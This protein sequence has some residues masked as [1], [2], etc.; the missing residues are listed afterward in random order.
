ML[1]ETKE[2]ALFTLINDY[3][4]VLGAV[5]LSPKT[6]FN[7]L[8]G[9]FGNENPHLF[10]GEAAL[11]LRL[12]YLENSIYYEKFVANGLR[13][14][15]STQVVSSGKAV[16][17]LYMRHP[18]YLYGTSHQDWHALSRDE[19]AGMTYLSA[20]IGKPE[21]MKEIIQ[22]GKEHNYAYI[23]ERPGYDP[24]KVAGGNVFAS[25]KKIWD[26]VKT[27]NS[28][29]D[30]FLDALSRIR[31]YNDRSF[32]KIGAKEEPSAF[33]SIQMSIGILLSA[34]TAKEDTSGKIMSFFKLVTF[35][36]LGYKT[37]TSRIIRKVFDIRLR[38]QYGNDYM[39]EIF[40]VYF[41][42][43]NHPFH[44]LVQGITL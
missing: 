24:I 5:T 42:D 4:D 36:I 20:A 22:Y 9:Q 11:L 40:K 35:D 30:I 41:K 27:K 39:A 38:R 34:F 1:N 8:I 32:Y 44:R 18:P 2:Q 6:L 7:P 25:I 10:N 31:Q 15:E 43:T 13:H 21:I 29:D 17:G 14:L 28:D 37:P 3:T 26:L 23:E 12:N 33:E 19:H 16:P